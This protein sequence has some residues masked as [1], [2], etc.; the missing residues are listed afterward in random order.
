MEWWSEVSAEWWVQLIFVLATA[1]LAE[2]VNVRC[3]LVKGRSRFT[4]VFVLLTGIACMFVVPSVEGSVAGLFMVLA[5]FL[6]FTTYQD[7]S[8]VGR[9]YAVYLLLGILSVWDIK[10]LYLT[11]FLWWWA[12]T[13]LQSMSLRSFLAS[14]LGIATPYW[15]LFAW[16]LF[17]QDFTP[18]AD[19]FCSF[20]KYTY[21]CEGIDIGLIVTVAIL[22]IL[23]AL[24]AL[25]YLRNTHKE[26]IRNRMFHYTIFTLG[27]LSCIITILQPSE[28]PWTLRLLAYTA[29]ASLAHAVSGRE[30]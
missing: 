29:S 2:V 30:R 11:P 22:V 19:H 27:F 9:T 8:A 14:L 21:S 6:L 5:L 26:S 28:A 20:A 24:G 12:T 10:L 25:H 17:N 16:A 7:H 18:L 1:I 13:W 15:L 3:V 23:L 4:F